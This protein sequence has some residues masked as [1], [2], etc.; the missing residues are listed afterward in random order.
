MELEIEPDARRALGKMQPKQAAKLVERLI[1]VAAEPFAT[2]AN[3]ERMKGE[4]D[5][6]RL[7]QGDWRAVFWIDRVA[8]TMRVTRIA[9]RG[10]VYK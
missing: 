1:K 3:V 10:E 6:F 5:T 9:P 7:R 4:A 2:H 8:Q